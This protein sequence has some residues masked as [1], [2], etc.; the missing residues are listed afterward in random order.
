MAGG[1][2]GIIRSLQVGKPAVYSWGGKEWTT[3]MGKQPAR[4]RLYLTVTGFEGDGQADLKNHGGR[5]KA[6]C[7]YSYEHYAYWVK[8]LGMPM[9]WA[10]FGE[11]VTMEGLTE[12]ETAIGDIYRMGEALVQVSQPRQPCYKL[13]HK[14]NRA[15]M[16]LLV[17]TTGY[18]GFYF[19]VLEEGYAAP[20]DSVRL[21]EPSAKGISVAEANR[22]MYACKEDKA[23]TERLLAV[24]EL[25]D[26]WRETLLKRLM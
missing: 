21:V 16:P 2:A 20:G 1:Q 17:Q 19:R 4:G 22:I 10:A 6:V 9:D 23:E 15:D 7:V 24:Q 8:E 5:D 25:S 18:T 14:Y 3:G 26:S 13:G 11:N 12:Q